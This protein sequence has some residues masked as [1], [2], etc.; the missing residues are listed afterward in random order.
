VLKLIY[1]CGC[2][3]LYDSVES[4]RGIKNLTER[5][6]FEN[7]G[8]RTESLKK[9]RS[10]LEFKREPVN[11]R[12]ETLTKRIPFEDADA[13]VINDMTGGIDRDFAAENARGVAGL[14]VVPIP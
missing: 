8:V 3:C 4:S 10:L 7:T 5:I 6:P 12:I 13:S 11:H 9:L 14:P 1:A 2:F